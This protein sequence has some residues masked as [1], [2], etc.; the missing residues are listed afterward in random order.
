MI[1]LTLPLLPAIFWD[2]IAPPLAAKLRRP[3]QRL[4]VL[5]PA[6]FAKVWQNWAERQRA[7]NALSIWHTQKRPVRLARIGFLSARETAVA[8]LAVLL[9][10]WNV[11]NIPPAPFYTESTPVPAWRSVP[12]AVWHPAGKAIDQ[13][14]WPFLARR[15]QWLRGSPS[16]VSFT[17]TIGLNQTWDMFSPDPQSND[18]WIVVA[19]TLRN[20]QI[21]D[22][23]SGAPVSYE[24]PAWVPGSYKTQLWMSYLISFWTPDSSKPDNFARYIVRTWNQSHPP[25]QRVD[26]IQIDM[27]AE[28]VEAGPAKSDAV[29]TPVYGPLSLR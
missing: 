16:L 5:R 25:D 29:R 18:G 21:V 28:T 20:G 11:S 1:T 12:A 27:M 19:G 2:R 17:Y 9:V 13:F 24:K 10:L 22:L 6:A 23:M 15:G 8:L 26:S 7:R 14:L 4:T 3:F